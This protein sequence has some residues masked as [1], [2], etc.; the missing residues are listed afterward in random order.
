MA[1]NTPVQDRVQ[2]TGTWNIDV[3]VNVFAS[4]H[5]RTPNGKTLQ[6]PIDVAGDQI[7][8]QYQEMARQQS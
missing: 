2:G 1:E 5:Y 3:P 8:V 7:T 4:A 6:V